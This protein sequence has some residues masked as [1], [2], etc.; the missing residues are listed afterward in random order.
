MRACPSMC[1]IQDFFFKMLGSRPAIKFVFISSLNG[2]F[3]F[4]TRD[5]V[6]DFF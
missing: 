6:L 5:K 4:L 3:E 1:F 2:F